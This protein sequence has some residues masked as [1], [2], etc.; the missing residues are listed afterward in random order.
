[1]I[2]QTIFD[3]VPRCLKHVWCYRSHSLPLAGFQMLK[4]VAY[5]LIDNV[6]HITPREESNEVKSGDL[7]G[8]A[9]G[10]PLPIHLPA[11]S[12]SR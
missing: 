9:I 12:L 5:N 1:M 6:L 3:L 11:I 8:Q 10:S 4:V 2:I 7:G